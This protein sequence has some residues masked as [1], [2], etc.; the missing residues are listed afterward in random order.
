MG[1]AARAGRVGVGLELG[2]RVGRVMTRGVVLDLEA[3]SDVGR[4]VVLATL[5]LAMGHDVDRARDRVVVSL[6]DLPGAGP[7]VSLIV[8]DHAAG[9]VVG[10]GMTPATGPGLGLGLGPGL[11]QVA[12]ATMGRGAGRAWGARDS[13]RMIMTSRHDRRCGQS[14]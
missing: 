11:D 1:H 6:K 10:Q 5:A 14:V 9:L 2:G 4:A 3:G 7:G 12:G 13:R 8:M